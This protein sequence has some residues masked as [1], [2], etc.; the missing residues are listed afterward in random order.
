MIPSSSKSSLQYIYKASYK[1]RPTPLPSRVL[2][3]S[4]M[5]F[6]DQVVLSGTALLGASF[7]TSSTVDLGY[8]AYAAANTSLT[9]GVTSFLGIRY[10]APPVGDL[11]FSAPRAPGPAEGVQQ[12]VMPPPCWGGSV[13][14]GASEPAYYNANGK[15]VNVSTLNSFNAA[16][17]SSDDCLFLKYVP[18]VMKRPEPK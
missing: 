5:G 8:A 13:F 12:S 11:R 18:L 17:S 7:S 6:Y 3:V 4:P 2:F 10:A 1:P 16:E 14:G 9:P 15:D